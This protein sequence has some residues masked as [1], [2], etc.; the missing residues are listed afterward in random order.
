MLM[1]T[2]ILQ[3][4]TSW[5]SNSSLLTPSHL[6]DDVQCLEG[7]QHTPDQ[8]PSGSILASLSD[9]RFYSVTDIVCVCS[10]STTPKWVYI[11]KVGEWPLYEGR[12]KLCIWPNVFRQLFVNYIYPFVLRVPDRLIQGQG[13]VVPHTWDLVTTTTCRKR[14]LIIRDILYQETTC[15][16]IFLAYCLC[17]F[18]LFPVQFGGWWLLLRNR[19]LLLINVV[20]GI[21]V[22][23]GNKPNTQE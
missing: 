3:N 13:Q 2:G 9:S 22:I 17:L 14:I 5:S 1:A 4:C 8:Y 18:G 19:L 10:E 21:L 15:A 23:I 11:S 16:D 12:Q 7:R 6:L 20:A